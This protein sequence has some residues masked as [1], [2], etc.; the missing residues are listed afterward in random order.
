[1]TPATSLMLAAG[2]TISRLELLV[3]LLEGMERRYVAVR[4]GASFHREW[5]QRMATLGREVQ[6]H[7]AGEVWQGVATDV[8]ADGAL[9]VRTRGGDVRRVLA[10]DVTLRKDAP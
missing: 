1:M 3:A 5:A 4:E 2:R 7:G 10:G 8:D 9:L 6:V